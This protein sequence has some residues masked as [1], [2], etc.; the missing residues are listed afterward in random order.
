M[1]FIDYYVNV[2]SFSVQAPGENIVYACR[3]KA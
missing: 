3:N 2:D 1:D